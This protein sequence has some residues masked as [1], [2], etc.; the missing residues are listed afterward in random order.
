[1]KIGNIELKNNVMLAPMAGITDKTFRTIC[2]EH[3]AGVVVTEMIST[4]YHPIGTVGR[5]NSSLL[6]C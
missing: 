4:N 6:C 1:M 2:K 3:G 5:N